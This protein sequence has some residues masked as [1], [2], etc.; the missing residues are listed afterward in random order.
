MFTRAGSAAQRIHGPIGNGSRLDLLVDRC[1]SGVAVNRREVGGRRNDATRTYI[2]G[3]ALQAAGRILNIY[4]DNSLAKSAMYTIGLED[5]LLAGA[6]TGSGTIRPLIDS[7]APA[8]IRYGKVLLA[9]NTPVTKAPV[10]LHT[11]GIDQFDR[12][13][14]GSVNG[15]PTDSGRNIF[16]LIP[17]DLN[18]GANGT[19]AETSNATS[20]IRTDDHPLAWRDA[21][22]QS[23]FRRTGQRERGCP[24]LPDAR[25]SITHRSAIL[26]TAIT[27]P[28][29]AYTSAIFRCVP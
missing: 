17:R 8:G 9:D 15:T 19:C 14:D 18:T 13:L 28:D 5:S 3:A 23:R 2:P 6:P 22:A 12:A 4:F 1:E 11:N 10:T 26:K 25:D 27:G 29:G 7:D 20:S 16:E 21:A 24:V